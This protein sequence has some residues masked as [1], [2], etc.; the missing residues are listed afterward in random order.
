MTREEIVSES[1]RTETEEIVV[2]LPPKTTHK[3][4]WG[5]FSQ[6]SANCAFAMQHAIVNFYEIFITQ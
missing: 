1:K 5:E 2:V 3:S 6:K 4:Q